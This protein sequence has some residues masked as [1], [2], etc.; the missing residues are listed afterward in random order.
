[1]R[2]RSQAAELEVDIDFDEASR[3]WNANKKRL[4]S[5]CYY[6]V[7]GA[8]LRNGRFC[9]RKPVKKSD[10][11]HEHCSLQSFSEKTT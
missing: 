6:Y 3:L 10:Y 7:C 8:E 9:K 4:A 1:M 5:G 2:T 11:C